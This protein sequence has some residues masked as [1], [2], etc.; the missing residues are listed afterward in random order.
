ML[1]NEFLKENRIVQEGGAT[2]VRQQNQIEALTVGLRRVS[3]Q[4]EVSKPVP[5]T[6]LSNQ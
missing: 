4:V 5:Q 2:I 3:A 6:V 1:L